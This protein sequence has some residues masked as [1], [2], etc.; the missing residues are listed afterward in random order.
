MADAVDMRPYTAEGSPGV[1]AAG[2]GR[3][4]SISVPDQS[5]NNIST[6]KPGT[7]RPSIVKRR[8]PQ[9]SLPK[10]VVEWE[11]LAATVL[12][13]TLNQPELPA[14]PLPYSPHSPNRTNPI[15]IP[16][17]RHHGNTSRPTTPLT[18]REEKGGYFSS[19]YESTPPRP[20]I[21]QSLRPGYHRPTE[22]EPSLNLGSW[23]KKFLPTSTLQQ[24]K[25][26]S[27]FSDTHSMPSD[28]KYRLASS[29]LSPSPTSP[30]SLTSAGLRPPTSNPRGKDMRLPPMPI[31]QYHPSN[32]ENSTASS[33]M[34][35]PAVNR[36]P[37]APHHH[38]HQSN[39]RLKLK[40][41]QRDLITSA[42]RSANIPI[43][44]GGINTP[45]GPHL[46]P[47]GSPGPTTPLTLDE[48]VDYMAAGLSGTMLG[49]GSS[50]EMVD[51]MIGDEN[52]RRAGVH[53]GPSSP[54]VSPAGGR[55]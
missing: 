52:D 13:T 42:T 49:E 22:R 37:V 16:I 38:R 1:A 10:V 35:G 3:S 48:Q 28:Q 20:Q 43:M 54:A 5:T 47:R 15:T 39:A 2:I 45:K 51:R 30:P 26:L 29:P 33:R 55:G 40:Q 7:A 50:R 53:S 18:A 31:P 44:P 6:P 14:T 41:Y 8:S 25:E 4:S 27:A 32:Y 46:Q 24:L 17:R 11:P 34:R 21:S 23:Q 19:V 9:A 36:S 12:H